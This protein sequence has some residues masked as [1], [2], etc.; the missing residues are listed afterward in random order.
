MPDFTYVARDRAGKKV[1]GTLSAGTQRDALAQLSQKLLFP[2]EVK[3]APPARPMFGGRRVSPTLLATFYGQLADL[4]HSGVPLLRSITVLEKQAKH[5]RFK[6]IVSDLRAKVEEGHSLSE[7]M[8]RH[9]LV[10]PELAVSIV[11]A[12]GEGGFLEE[13]L[14]QISEFTEKQEDLKGRTMGAVAYPAF[15]LAVGVLVVT[16]LMI[17][18]VPRFAGI[19]ERLREKGE[20]PALTEALL[21]CSELMQNYGLVL[22]G[23]LVAGGMAIRYYLKTDPGRLM[24]DRVLIRIPLAGAVFLNLAVS[25]FCRV[26][27]T[28]LKNG[29]PILKSLEISSDSTGNRVLAQAIRKAAENISSGESLAKPLAASGH[30]PSNVVEMIAVAEESNSLEKVLV[31][32]ADGLDRRTWRQLELVVRLLEPLLLLLLAVAVLLIVLALLLPVIK[33]SMTM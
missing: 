5:A 25:R 9:P 23:G 27:G 8:Q 26:L 32:V 10:F 14:E 19:F 12:G 7:C 29:V 18:L 15:L 17:F 13:A 24:F 21:W 20:L 2:L 30:F 11:R 4:L 28:L 6:E 3:T 22:L 31:D 16:G 1:Q 33:M